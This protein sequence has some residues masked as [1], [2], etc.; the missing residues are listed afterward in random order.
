MFEVALQ[1]APV[2][3][4]PL[5]S[6]KH[7]WFTPIPALSTGTIQIGRKF[8]IGAKIRQKGI[9]SLFSPLK[10]SLRP[11]RLTGNKE[12]LDKTGLHRP[13]GPVIS[14]MQVA[15]IIHAHIALHKIDG[16]GYS[17]DIGSEA[18]RPANQGAA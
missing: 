14:D 3:P 8:A 16:Q 10:T 17:A 15:H 12:R 1:P 6:E 4:F 2:H 11:P 13:I 9:Y 18:I 7:L 5:R